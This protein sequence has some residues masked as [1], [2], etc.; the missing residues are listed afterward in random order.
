[1]GGAPPVRDG[2]HFPPTPTLV[3]S[4]RLVWNHRLRV[5]GAMP[6]RL[7]LGHVWRRSPECCSVGAAFAS[8]AVAA[9]F[10]TPA[11]HLLG[12]L[13]EAMRERQDGRM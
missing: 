7:L 5:T 8:G 4:V 12:H 2:A 9:S 10:I 3:G 6:S 11:S 13:L 1:M